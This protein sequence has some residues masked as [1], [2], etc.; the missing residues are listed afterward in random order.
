MFSPAYARARRAGPA[1]PADFAAANVV[2]YRRGGDRWALTEYRAA[3]V[4]RSAD[5]LRIGSAAAVW[6]GDVLEL[7]LAE[8]CAPFGGRVAGRVRLSPAAAGGP[9]ELAPGQ[10]WWPVA[11]VARA[12]VILD[13]PRLRFAGTAYHDANFGDAP[14]ESAF[15]RWDWCRADHPEGTA[16]VYDAVDR[17]GTWR[18]WARVFGADGC[19][20]PFDGRINDLGRTMW[21]IPRRVRTPGPVRPV[22]TLVD[23]PFYARTWLEASWNGRWRSAVHESVD[24][25]RFESRWVQFLL[26]FKMRGGWR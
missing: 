16:V 23:A 4:D 17:R 14:L 3:A 10:W 25:R 9:V 5:A 8:R 12:E 13:E 6:R 22:R 19:E 15:A 1:A 18:P 2:L 24:L 11:P 7:E 26:P 21:G 20:R